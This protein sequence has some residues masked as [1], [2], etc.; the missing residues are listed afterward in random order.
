MSQG[1]PDLLWRGSERVVPNLY[2]QLPAGVHDLSVFFLA[3]T[4]PKSMEPATVKLEV[5][6]DGVPLQGKPVIS[7][8]KAG[9]ESSP[10]LESFSINSAEDGAYEIARNP[11]PGRKASGN[12][13]RVC[14]DGSRGA[15]CGGR[16][17]RSAAADRSSRTDSKKRDG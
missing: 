17:R 4:D 16:T 13:G 10:V 3:H 9:A 6:H 11:H 8:L 5:L 2:G 7:T 14:L 12:D 1:E 15:G